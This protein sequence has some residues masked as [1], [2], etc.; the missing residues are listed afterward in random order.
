MAHQPAANEKQ[1]SRS[2]P[3]HLSDEDLDGD[4]SAFGFLTL[5]RRPGQAGCHSVGQKAH[6]RVH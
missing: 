5:A 1:L 2:S 6:V 3:H 4:R